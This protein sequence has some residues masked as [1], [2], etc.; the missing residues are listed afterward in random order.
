MLMPM[1]LL[2]FFVLFVR[3]FIKLPMVF[4]GLGFSILGFGLFVL[5]MGKLSGLGPFVVIFVVFLVF[6]FVDSDAI[7]EILS[8]EI[9]F[10]KIFKVL[11]FFGLDF[12]IIVSICGEV[13]KL[14]DFVFF[15]PFF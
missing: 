9:D 6:R 4:L 15:F 14:V 2:G 11:S 13:V 7:I 8:F 1:L 5:L 10:L 12:L 3:F